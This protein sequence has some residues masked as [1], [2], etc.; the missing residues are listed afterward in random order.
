MTKKMMM[1]AA[2]CLLV[3]FT[4]IPCFAQLEGELKDGV[5]VCACECKI[6]CEVFLTDG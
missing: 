5:E 1:F 6:D 2:A 4:A 3:V